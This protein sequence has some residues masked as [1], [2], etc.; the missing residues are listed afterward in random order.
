[1]GEPPH[2]ISIALRLRFGMCHLVVQLYN[3]TP[4]RGARE[5]RARVQA[6]PHPDIE[7]THLKRKQQGR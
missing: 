7:N 3:C 2:T 1:M 5:P 4:V 6:A